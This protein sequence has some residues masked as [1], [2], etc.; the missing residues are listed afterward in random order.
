MAQ[1]TISRESFMAF[2][3]LLD[4]DDLVFLDT[5]NLPEFLDADDDKIISLD[6]RYQGRLDLLSFD[7][8]GTTKYWWVIAYVNGIT[9]VPTEVMVGRVIR[10]PTNARVVD[11]LNRALS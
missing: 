5:P 11:F 7:F 4:S 2:S 10:L 3:D 6:Q 8:Y 9:Q 1:A